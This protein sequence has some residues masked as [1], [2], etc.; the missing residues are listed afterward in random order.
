MN[1]YVADLETEKAAWSIVGKG[2]RM[3][4]AAPFRA[5]W[6]GG[7]KAVKGVAKGTWGGGKL[8]AKGALGS[9]RRMAVTGTVAG[10][11][12]FPAITMFSNPR[13]TRTVA[14]TIKSQRS[15]AEQAQKN[16]IKMPKP[17]QPVSPNFGYA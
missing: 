11:T 8:L 17:P 13:H 3:A 10:L 15:A 12:A 16:M 1:P 4:V 7:S 2:I 5:G 14:D 6:W 9:Q